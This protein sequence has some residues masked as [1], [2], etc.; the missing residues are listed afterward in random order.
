MNTKGKLIVIEGTDGSGKATQL[1]LLGGRMK[2]EK[3]KFITADFPRYGNP[4]A[5]FVEKYLRGEYG[6]SQELGSYVPSYFYALDRFD[7]AFEIRKKLGQGVAVIS[8][9]YTTSNM[10]HQTGKIKDKKG[11]DKFL[12]W[13]KKLEYE[14]LK[15]PKP[16]A[17]IFLSVAPEIGQKLV[18]QKSKREYTKGKKRDIHEAD[19]EHLKRAFDTYHYVAKKDRWI[20]VDCAPKGQL[21][22]RESIHEKIWEKVKEILK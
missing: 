7:A 6:K 3:I 19:I 12:N 16:D 5:H 13:L 4:S 1:A 21:L 20:V 15:I 17:V 8:N 2:K 14:E 9:R 10:G 11:K 18:G 22:S